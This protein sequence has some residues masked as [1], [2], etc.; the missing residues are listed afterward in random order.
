[1][2]IDVEI[3]KMRIAELKHELAELEDELAHASN[4]NGGQSR[5][6]SYRDFYGVLGGRLNATEELL[7][8]CRLKIDWD[9][10]E[11]SGEEA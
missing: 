7:E 1:M 4:G 2:A 11:P 10:L 3:V 8:E 9:K 6:T 5:R